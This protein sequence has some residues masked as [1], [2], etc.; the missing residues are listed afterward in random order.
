MT[1][2]LPF[3][4]GPLRSLLETP[5]VTD[6]L[7]NGPDE[8]WIDRGL[9]LERA[10]VGFGAAS[11][12]RELAVRL[13]SLGGRRLDDASPLVDARLP[14]G[15][16]LHAALPPVVD[17]CAT[18]SLRTVRRSALTLGDLELCGTLAPGFAAVLEGLVVGRASLLI[19]GATGSG[20]TTLLASLL[21]LVDPAE[22]IVVIEEA[23]EVN[24]RHPHVV[25]L[26]ERRAN[27]DG[28]G[29]IGVSR[30]VREALRMRPDRIVL[31]ECRG[32]EVRDVLTALNTGHRGG[33]ATLHAN[34]PADVPARL[35]ALG[36]L[37][38]MDA[39]ATDLHAAAAF[40]AVIHLEKTAAGRRVTELA[41]LRAGDGHRAA[42]LRVVAA[43]RAAPDGRTEAGPA[44]PEIEALLPDRQSGPACLGVAA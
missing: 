36:A 7:V 10:G 26:V 27:V 43:L 8:V 21:S 3:V 40:E 29:A 30:L 28:A 32:P 2:P 35:A 5:G 24:P 31:G 12:V 13:A 34:A 39:R 18:I 44:W 15:T 19:T 37:A 14:D 4:V 1:T 17:G 6:V 16:R 25:R 42:R 9:G 41:I 22:R 33:M 11:E 20:K 38:G 23:G